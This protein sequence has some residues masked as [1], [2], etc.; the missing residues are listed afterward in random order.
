MPSAKHGDVFGV[1]HIFSTLQRRLQSMGKSK[2]GGTQWFKTINNFRNKG[3]RIEEFDASNLALTLDAL[4]QD[5]QKGKTVSAFELADLCN[6]NNLRFSVIPVVK[7]AQRPMHFGKPPD[8]KLKRT[9][10]VPKAVANL[11][12]RVTNFDRVLGY[13]IE[14]VEHQSLWGP[15]H[16]WQAVTHEGKIIQNDAKVTGFQTAQEAVNLAASHAREHFPKRVALCRWG[17]WAWSGGE[18]YREWLIT[19]P[20]YPANYLAGHFDVRNVLTHVR[21]DVREDGDG[22]RVLML[23]EVQ[24]D[25]AQRARRGYQ[26]GGNGRI[27]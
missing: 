8:R 9:K 10:K 3:V 26:R 22:R 7:D 21:C 17:K 11:P 12:R 5:D 20:H 13:R 27:R 6:F 23:H 16:T 18:G 15:E 19:L 1:P 25:W 14:R 4:D 2:A 24:S